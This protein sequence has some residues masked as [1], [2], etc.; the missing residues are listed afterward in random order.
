M[1][2]TGNRELD[3]ILAARRKLKPHDTHRLTRALSLL[4]TGLAEIQQAAEIIRLL[5]EDVKNR[6]EESCPPSDEAE[7]T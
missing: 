3:A 2:T 5:T 7:D 4:E 1:K 6:M